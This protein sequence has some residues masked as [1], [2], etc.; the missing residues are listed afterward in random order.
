M[1]VFALHVL[2]ATQCE[3]IKNVTSFVGE[4]ESGRFG[5]LAG[6]ARMIT[7]LSYGLARYQLPNGSLCYHAFTGGIL[8]FK[9]NCLHISTRHFLHDSNYEHISSGLVEKLLKE[10]Q[11]LRVIKD[12]LCQLE[13]EMFRRLW[14]MGRRGIKI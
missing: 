14:Q 3:T 9:N 1:N 6:H 5:I 2:S 8:Y 4:D 13:Q 11:D 10:E 7:A 12:S